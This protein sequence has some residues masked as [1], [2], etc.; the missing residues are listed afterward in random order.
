MIDDKVFQQ[1]GKEFRGVPFW[2][3]NTKLKEEMIDRQI[4]DFKKMG[5]GGFCIHSRTGLDTEY[6]GPEFM[7]AVRQSLEKA[8]ELDEICFLYDED[9]WPSGYGGGMVTQNPEFRSKYLVL[10]PWK[11]GTRTYAAQEYTAKAA[12]KSHGQGEFLVAFDILLNEDGTLVGY[13]QR[14]EEDPVTEGMDRW[15]VY[16]ESA[17]DSPWYNNQS[18]V[19]TLNPRAIRCFIESTYEAYY[20]EFGEEFGKTIPA[21]FTDEPQFVH[22]QSLAGPFSKQN[23]ILPF[24]SDFP[25]AYKEEYGEEFFKSLPELYWE[26]P[27]GEISQFRYQYQELVS[28]RFAR[29]YGDQIGAWCQEHGIMLCGH[30]MMEPKLYYQTQ[31]VGEVMRSLRGFQLPGVDILCD[32]REYTTVKQAE[33][34]AHQMGRSGVLSEELGV[35][36]WDFDFRSHKLHGDWQA[37]L[38]VTVRV[39]HLTWMSMAGESKRDY[40]A[41]I[42]YQSPWYEKYPL[43]EDHF[44]RVNTAMTQGRP[45]VRVGMIHPVESCWLYCGNNQQTGQVRELL[46]EQFAQ[47]TEWLLFG[48]LDFD[49]ISES[50]LCD[51]GDQGKVGCMEYDIILVAGCR[52]LRDTTLEFL[53]ACKALGKEIVFA[54]DVPLY[55]DAQ[56]N[57]G[58]QMFAQSCRCVEFSRTAILDS[59]ESVRTIEMRYE[60]EKYLKKPREKKS[61]D[62]I[63]AE[64]YVY[65]QRQDGEEVYF[66]IAH[67]KPM[68][69]PDLVLEDKMRVCIKGLWELECLDTMNGERYPI[70]VWHQGGNTYFGHV[71]YEQDSLLVHGTPAVKM[72]TEALQTKR[73]EMVRATDLFTAQVEITREE[74]NVMVLDIGEFS[75]DGG[76][77]EGMEE[78]LRLDNVCRDRAGYPPRR[79][80]LSQPY[81][82]KE[83]PV[84]SHAI[85]LRYFIFSDVCVGN[86]KAAFENV[87]QMQ[88][89]WDGEKLKVEKDGCFIDPCMGT[90]PLPEVTPG[91]H[92]LEL[93]LP[94]TEKTNLEAGFLLGDFGVRTQGAFSRLTEKP[95]NYFWG[96]VTQQG[97]PFYGGNVTYGTEIA[98]EAG[99]YGLEISKYRGALL[100]VRID[101]RYV[102]DIFSSPY[103]VLFTVENSGSHYIEI[104]C[105]GNRINTFGTLHDCDEKE[106][107]YEPNSWRTTEEGWSYEYQLRRMG[108][109]KAPVLKQYKGE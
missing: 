11:K 87:E 96:S 14:Q 57:N 67:G 59:L 89:F 34:V 66:F 38:G 95:E 82:M 22:R 6:L 35:T 51:L 9:R 75:F 24:T 5:M 94:F 85:R 78:I 104:I 30:V 64:G 49:Y 86:V 15:Y 52:T 40:P 21:I 31:A 3:W 76:P 27:N 19:D 16:V 28:E 98:L 93:E 45:V 91:T 107:Y 68:E 63:R 10:T 18:Y 48:M 44:A 4:E 65:Q 36:N 79:A 101:G 2:S 46:D 72:K 55:V 109:L 99:S 73:A 62:G 81:T 26:L 32:S 54:G 41:S 61:W 102:G 108:I 105:Y 97:M 25:Q 69:N 39:H 7:E 84:P 88:V 106:I 83:E 74:P 37:A 1:P 56:R 20:R 53:K 60:G 17:Q 13:E 77:W 8:K 100:E 29:A 43:I 47:L 70:D 23:V 33:S 80:A 12:T 92:T 90:I 50:L 58:V 71:F 42:G 103:E